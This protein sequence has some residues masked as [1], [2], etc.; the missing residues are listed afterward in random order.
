MAQEGE[1]ML[2]ISIRQLEVFVATAEYC[3]F[4]KAAED[5]HLTQ[6]TVSM[7]I[8]TL[9]EV[10]NTCLIERGARKKVILTEEGKRVYTMAKDILSRME[11]L[12][13]RRSEG[14]EE[15][16]RIGTSTVPAQYLLP[17]LLSGC[18][19]K[20]PHARYILRRGDSEHILGC[21]QKGEIRIGLVGYKNSDRS[22]IFQEIARDH[23]VLITENSEAYRALQAAGKTGQDLLDRPMIAREESSGTQ[24]AADAF[25]QRLGVQAPNIVARMDNP[26]SIKMSVAE[27]IGVSIVSDLAVSA[28]LRA[29]KLLA[30][31]FEPQAEARKLYIVWPRDALLT[32]T[33]LKFI[34][35]VKA[36]TSAILLSE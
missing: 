3:S 12:Q 17:K 24:H 30:F 21:L 36:Q 20:H 23:L 1:N 4:T 5:L 13:E 7:H 32:A 34:Q 11:A 35:H 8:R 2:D 19:K 29:E 18:L 25:L 10:L 16:L 33:E 9:E 15:P 28:E 26:E 27:G 6:S 14:A 31:P 22:L